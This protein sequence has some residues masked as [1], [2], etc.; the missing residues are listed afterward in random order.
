MPENEDDGKLKEIVLSIPWSEKEIADEIRL[1]HSRDQLYVPRTKDSTAFDAWIP[2]IGA[3][4][5]SGGKVNS[6]RDGIR[7]DL[8]IL[9][10]DGNKLYWLVTPQ[11]Y[12]LFK[13]KEPMD[14][15]QYVVR[16]PYPSVDQ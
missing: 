4:K 5:K 13:K 10:Q 8:A 12:P 11:L 3:F 1:D 9:G 15:D 16:I 2:G 7:D 6:S 14:I